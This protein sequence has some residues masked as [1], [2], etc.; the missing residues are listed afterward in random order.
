MESFVSEVLFE[1]R[2]GDQ[3]PFVK[4]EIKNS[5]EY[6]ILLGKFLET[7]RKDFSVLET[8]SSAG[9]PESLSRGIIQYRLRK[10]VSEKFPLVQLGPG[11][12]TIN[13]DKDNWTEFKS[14]IVTSVEK[15]TQISKEFSLE[16]IK[17]KLTYIL[18]KDFDFEKEDLYG[19]LK[20]NLNIEISMGK[21]RKLDKLQT[22]SF[23]SQV[24]YENPS[25]T[26]QYLVAEGKRNERKSIIW[27]AHLETEIPQILNKKDLIDWLQSA[28]IE[29]RRWL[30]I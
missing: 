1:I 5:P 17:I 12:F 16:R 23:K 6:N 22:I 27:Q 30:G 11:V 13:L 3:N 20:K 19:F 8:L 29:V 24:Q 15:F 4:G 10:S 14:L 18:A 21:D 26:L 28:N 7:F 25:G 9:V 2:W